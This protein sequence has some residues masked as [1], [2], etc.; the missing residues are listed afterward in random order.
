MSLVS[1]KALQYV[2]DMYHD[3]IRSRY[4]T[5]PSLVFAERRLVQQG[6]RRDEKERNR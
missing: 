1:Q 2:L 4:Q 3:E 6:T 5:L